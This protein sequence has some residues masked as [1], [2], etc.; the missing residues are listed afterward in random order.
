MERENEQSLFKR[1]YKKID[2]KKGYLLLGLIVGIIWMLMWSAN[3]IN[4]GGDI[5]TTI[6]G[7]LYFIPVHVF[8]WW[9]YAKIKFDWL[10]LDK[11][12]N[13]KEKKFDL[14]SETQV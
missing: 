6:V 9:I 12:C 8:F 5:L 10:H 14:E 13:K 2:T 4:H 11:E 1:I 7:Y 3:S